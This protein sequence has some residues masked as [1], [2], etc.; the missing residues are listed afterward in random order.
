MTVDENYLGGSKTPTNGADSG[1][2]ID[3]EN[4][5]KFDVPTVNVPL[6]T[7]QPAGGEWNVYLTKEDQLTEKFKELKFIIDNEKVD[8]ATLF[9]GINNAGV[10]V[11]FGLNNSKGSN[12][13]EYTVPA[14]ET[15][16]DWTK[17]MPTVFSDTNY[18]L[19]CKVEDKDNVSIST[20]SEA[21]VK[22]N[23][24]KPVLTFSDMNVYYG[25]RQPDLSSVQPNVAWTWKSNNGEEEKQDTEVNMT[26]ANPPTLNY[27]Y[28]GAAGETVNQTEDYTVS[29][30][31]I[32]VQGKENINLLNIDN[33]VTFLRNC[34]TEN[35]NGISASAEEAFKIH[36]KTLSL[37]ITKKVE[38]QLANKSEK[39]SFTV[40]ITPASGTE[41]DTVTKTFSLGDSEK[42]VLDKLPRGASFEI[43]ENNVP[44]IYDVS[45]EVDGNKVQTDDKYK[46]TGMLSDD[47]DLTTVAVTNKLETA[48]PTGIDVGTPL[49]GFSI[50]LF[51]M[52][53]IIALRIISRITNNKKR[54]KHCT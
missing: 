9:N 38:G 25:D 20:T 42:Q 15:L 7:V 36:V 26:T 14:G 3:G 17:N 49:S 28:S 39:F 44:K 23:V 5:D 43:V 30:A 32:G 4:I 1:I 21:N 24:F 37:S 31:K 18:T 33:A 54:S 11:T 10:N 52:S 2:Y 8:F 19:Y 47:N 50:V 51:S 40:K 34:E 41:L 29:V 16:D 35:L 22:I 48:P 27:T 53:G 13:Y 12:V 6:K 45:F 46:V